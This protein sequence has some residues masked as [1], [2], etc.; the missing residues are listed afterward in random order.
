MTTNRH[1]LGSLFHP[2]NTAFLAEVSA[3]VGGLAETALVSSDPDH[4][5][6]IH[7][8]VTS[9]ALQRWVLAAGRHPCSAVLPRGGNCKR[10]TGEEPI[11]DPLCWAEA[12]ARACAWHSR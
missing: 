5:V 4:D 9:A 7:F 8:K 1:P 2:Q 11:L 12:S 3:A 6:A 10:P